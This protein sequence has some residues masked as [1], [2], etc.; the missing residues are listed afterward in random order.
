M[1]TDSIKIDRSVDIVWQYFT[2]PEKW[3]IWYG[4]GLEKVVPGWQDGAK[5]FWAVGGESSIEKIIPGKEICISGGWMDKTYKFTP[6]GKTGTIVE[7]IE[8][9][10]KDGAS[11][12]D[13]G[14]AHKAEWKKTLQRLKECVES[15]YPQDQK[16]QKKWWEFWK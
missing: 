4:G 8:S 1:I 2:K 11:F 3:S 15:E 16:P 9:D 6:V 12:N 13:G 10:P 14:A 7:V 5:L